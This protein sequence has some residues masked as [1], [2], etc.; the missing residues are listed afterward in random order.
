MY[1]TKLKWNKFS[2]VRR[3]DKHINNKNFHFSSIAST[4]FIEF[5]TKHNSIGKCDNTEMIFWI[6]DDVGYCNNWSK[7]HCLFHYLSIHCSCF[8]WILSQKKNK[9]TKSFVEESEIFFVQ[10]YW[11]TNINHHLEIMLIS[12][13]K[14]WMHF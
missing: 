2:R 8:W 13:V 1:S 6:D 14:Y 10:K 11:E 7:L 5:P 3:H 9:K 4:I 12:P